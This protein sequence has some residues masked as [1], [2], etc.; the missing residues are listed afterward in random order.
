M[1]GILLTQDNII[2]QV[3]IALDVDNYYE[4]NIAIFLHINVTN[5]IPML[6]HCFN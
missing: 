4:M 3:L 1:R 5:Q 2:I 6:D